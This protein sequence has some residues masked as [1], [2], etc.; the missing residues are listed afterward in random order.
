MNALLQTAFLLIAAHAL[1][2]RPF[3][4]PEMREEKNRAKSRRW[5]YGL[6]VHG[7]IHGGAVAVIT[8]HWWL[9]VAETILHALIDDSKCMG[10]I[11]LKTDQALHLT[12]KMLWAAIAWSVS[13]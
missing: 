8:G 2:D 12:C 11:D 6:A 7:L 5:P 13:P 1:C 4:T 10:R 3:Q 9:G